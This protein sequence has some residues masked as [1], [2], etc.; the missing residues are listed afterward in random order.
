MRLLK[1]AQISRQVFLSSAAQFPS[2]TPSFAYG[3]KLAEQSNEALSTLKVFLRLGAVLLTGATSSYR[4]DII[5]NL[6]SKKLVGDLEISPLGSVFFFL[7]LVKPPSS[8]GL[9]D[10]LRSP[11]YE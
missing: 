9:W 8:S 4:I 1:Q 3:P 7:L 5:D 11:E 10:L 2:H 6:D